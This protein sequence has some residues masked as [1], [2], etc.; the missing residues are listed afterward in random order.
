M[1][2]KKSAKLKVIEELKEQNLITTSE[3]DSI[4]SHYK[5]EREKNPDKLV[6]NL[7]GLAVF[8][9]AISIITIFAINWEEFG[10]TTRAILSYI[11]LFILIGIFGFTV[12]E[13]DDAKRNTKKIIL[14]IFAPIAIIASNALIDQTF[15]IQTTFYDIIV[16]SMW[17]FIPIVIY[18]L[19]PPALFLFG[20]GVIFSINSAESTILAQSIFVIISILLNGYMW[21]KDKTRKA[22]YNMSVLNGALIINFLATNDIINLFEVMI[23]I[24]AV[25]EILQLIYKEKVMRLY[26]SITFVFEVVIII[27]G[28]FENI[29]PEYSIVTALILLLV[30]TGLFIYNKSFKDVVNISALL[31]VVSI[32]LGNQ[33]LF[34]ILLLLISAG[35]FYQGYNEGNNSRSMRGVSL[36]TI[37]G[38]SKL[39]TS[40][41]SFEEKSVLF[42]VIGIIF[43]IISKIV[44]KKMGVAKNEE[45]K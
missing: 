31:I 11:P 3:Y 28:L 41:L 1:N 10:I 35:Y 23:S 12:F 2:L 44:K 25:L 34:N 43:I 7:I 19:K 8:F 16:N 26:S 9:I 14:S 6:N 15:Q 20:L 18:T 39:V 27:F 4:C 42:I 37:W 32:L 24:F 21:Y 40:E 38:L 30:Q 36:V 29:E 22:T 45:S 13:K 17:A 33:L 5:F